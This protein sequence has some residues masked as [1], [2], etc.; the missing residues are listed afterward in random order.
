MNIVKFKFTYVFKQHI[1]NKIICNQQR[2]L[3]YS[4]FIW[5]MSVEH[6]CAKRCSRMQA[7]TVNQ[8]VPFLKE[9][10]SP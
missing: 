6:L 10:M 9:T 4:S 8:I 2:K 1:L 3:I 5:L 7:A